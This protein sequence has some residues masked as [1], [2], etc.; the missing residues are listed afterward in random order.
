M[1]RIYYN[2]DVTIIAAAGENSEYGIPGVGSIPR[3]AQRYVNIGRHLLVERRRPWSDNLNGTRWNTRGWTYQEKL[4]SRRCLVFTDQ[5]AWF[6]CSRIQANEGSETVPAEVR[7]LQLQ[8][9]LGG[10]KLD[11]SPKSLPFT[12]TE[13]E[14]DLTH[15]ISEF[16]GRTLTMPSDV[17]NAFSGIL[18]VFEQATHPTYHVWGVLPVIIWRERIIETSPSDAFVFGL[19][20]IPQQTIPALRLQRRPDFPSWSWSG[21]IGP[22][23]YYS[24][25]AAPGWDPEEQGFDIGVAA[26]VELRDGTV[27]ALS[28]LARHPQLRE[29]PEL[30]SPFIHLDAWMVGVTLCLGEELGSQWG[31]GAVWAQVELKDGTRAFLR[32]EILTIARRKA[33]GENFGPFRGKHV[34]GVLLCSLQQPEWQFVMLVEEKPTW[35]ERIGR[36]DTRRFVDGNGGDSTEKLVRNKNGDLVF[37]L[38]LLRA[39]RRNICLG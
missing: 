17:I 5:E 35:A 31:S 19:C 24:T 3:Q 36:I 13:G 25:S 39:T 21:W 32:A 28:D 18:K 33:D 8:Y 6:T 14:W 7:R 9:E 2:A 10:T 1:D 4:L 29:Q 23:M 27:L 34:T 11:S 26:S 16:S 30:V 12:T 37:N 22:I 15:L 20:W 38:N